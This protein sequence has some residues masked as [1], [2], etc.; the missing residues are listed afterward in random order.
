M[1]V[2]NPLRGERWEA[3][4][5]TQLDVRQ[6]VGGGGS[7]GVPTVSGGSAVV[8][9][10]S[11]RMMELSN[12]FY[13]IIP[14]TSTGDRNTRT[15][16]PPINSPALLKSKIEMIEALGN[17]ELASRVIDTKSA[18]FDTHPIDARYA[19]L[20]AS[21]TPIDVG[22]ALHVMLAQYLKQTHGST[23]ATYTLELEQAF[24]VERPGEAE[25][26]KRGGAI[27]NRQLLWH[28]SRLTNWCGILSNG[29]RIAPPEAPVTGYMFGKGLYFANMSSKSANYCFA[30]QASPT[31]VLLLCD[32]ALGTPYTKVRADYDAD[33]ACRK[34][35]ANSTWG[36]GKTCPDPAGNRKLPS[37]GR[38]TVP[39]GVGGPSGVKDSAL[40]Y[41]EFI[42][43]DASQVR[44]KY[45][46]QVKF[47]FK[48]FY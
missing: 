47:H 23:H 1:H 42:V 33:K 20:N 4:H 27:G 36:K 44:Q 7:S 30:H 41:D 18:A 13:S 11:G 9:G 10:G 39:M 14:H 25:A 37:D 48:S 22:S 31:G 35:S 28:G 38:V 24:E 45:V 21:L 43:Y 26:F 34:A 5:Q 8:A 12:Q 40:L 16:L 29:L 17:I 46:L 19:G 2:S 6:G 32:V 15:P 3:Q